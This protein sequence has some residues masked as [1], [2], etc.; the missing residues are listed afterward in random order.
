MVLTEGI[1]AGI[2]AAAC[3]GVADFLAKKAVD[4]VGSLRTLFWVQSIG[5]L[6]L[7]PALAFVPLG[8]P[9][10]GSA[11][12]LALLIGVVNVT[13][14]LIFY[15]GF[16]KGKLSVISPIAGSAGA[17]TVVLGLALLGERLLPVQGAGVLL[18]LIGVPLVSI[19]MKEIRGKALASLAAGV[20]EAVFSMLGWGAMWFL[21]AFVEGWAGWLFVILAMRAVTVTCAGAYS[22]MGKEG[23]ALGKKGKGLWGVIAAAG[24]LDA[25]GFAS[26]GF[27]MTTEFASIVTPI[28]SAYPAVTVI[29]AL[30]LLRERLLATQLLGIVLVLVG[31][32]ALS[33]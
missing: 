8:I 4:R 31:V 11:F 18:A 6:A 22:G 1:A 25:V 17:V 28:A 10:N 2:L 32:A 9:S 15:R 33:A 27:A 12:G 20:P 29:L 14:Y 30:V 24:I 16:E 5:L 23:V 7:L 3:W 21:V 19:D 26:L 13:T